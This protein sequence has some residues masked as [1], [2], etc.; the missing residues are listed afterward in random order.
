MKTIPIMAGRM[1]ANGNSNSGS[2]L[3]GE[4]SSP[5]SL[6][7]CNELFSLSSE[8]GHVKVLFAL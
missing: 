1:I 6:G 5:H 8:V 7:G 3:S 2:E 4:I